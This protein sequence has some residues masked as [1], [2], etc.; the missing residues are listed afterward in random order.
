MFARG[1]TFVSTTDEPTFIVSA[2]PTR[3]MKSTFP[4]RFP[5]L[6]VS[7]VPLGWIKVVPVE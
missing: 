2:L 7:V 1:F 4:V 6:R 3:K 5:A